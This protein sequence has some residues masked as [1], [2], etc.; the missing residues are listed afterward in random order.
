MSAMLGSSRRDNRGRVRLQNGEV[1]LVES[2]NGPLRSWM[3]R[4][5]ARLELLFSSSGSRF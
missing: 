3:L 4:L 1:V 5:V 2:S